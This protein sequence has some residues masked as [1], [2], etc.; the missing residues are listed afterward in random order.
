[1]SSPKNNTL[2]ALRMILR[3]LARILLRAGVTWKEVASL[4]KQVFVEVA[5]AEFGKGGRPTNVS[6]VAILTG[7]TRREVARLRKVVDNG[8]ASV[9]RDMNHATRVLTGW[10]TDDDFVEQ[11]RRAAC[12]RQRRF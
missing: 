11:Q 3:P 12:T 6:R 4:G 9:I 8:E 10:Y 7:F 5:S 2:A 1:M